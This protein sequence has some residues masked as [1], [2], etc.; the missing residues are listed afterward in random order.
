MTGLSSIL[1]DIHRK[2]SPKSVT[3]ANGSLAKIIG[4]GSTKLRKSITSSSV[5]YVPS[6]RLVCCLLVKLLNVLND[7]LV[8]TPLCVSFQNLNMERKIGKGI[9]F[10]ASIIFSFQAFTLL[11]SHILIIIPF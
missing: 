2:E 7:Q 1:S 4:V 5:L 10:V 3:H 9:K 11:S 6:F 8:F